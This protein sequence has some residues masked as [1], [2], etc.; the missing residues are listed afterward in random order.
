MN[1]F[2]L[3]LCIGFMLC[4]SCKESN[5]VEVVNITHTE[6]TISKEEMMVL[7][8]SASWC[9]PCRQL[10]ALVESDDDIQA[11]IGEGYTAW[12]MIDVDNPTPRQQRLINQF[13]PRGIPLVKSKCRWKC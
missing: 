5:K 3:I 8:F 12:E 9:P 1:R 10:K 6:Q 7:Q 4:V 13:G 2:L 11:A